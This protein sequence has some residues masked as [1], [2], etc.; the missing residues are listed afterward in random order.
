MGIWTEIK[1]RGK[2]NRH[3]RFADYR[4]TPD[5][6]DDGSWYTA[7]LFRDEKHSQFGIREWY[8]DMPHH[9]Y[10]RRLAARVLGDRAFRNTL[11]SDR[12]E[13]LKWWKRK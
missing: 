2:Q 13:L 8:G 6:R 9:Q 4:E 1:P 11:M 12:P 7:F 5:E 10:L 3:W